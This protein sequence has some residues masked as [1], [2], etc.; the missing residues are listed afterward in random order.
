MEI[1]EIYCYKSNLSINQQLR[2][3]EKNRRLKRLAIN[4]VISSSCARERDTV[5]NVV[6]S[7]IFSNS[8][9]E[10]CR[11]VG[12]VMCGINKLQAPSSQANSR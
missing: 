12:I 2:I 9:F 6:F 4:F 3:A 8:L 1:L 11:Y 5:I 7:V 10:E